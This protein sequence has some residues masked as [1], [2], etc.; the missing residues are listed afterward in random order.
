MT[1]QQMQSKLQAKQEL[2]ISIMGEKD[3][4][5]AMERALQLVKAGKKKITDIIDL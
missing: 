1:T 3:G 5:A 4:K 2:L